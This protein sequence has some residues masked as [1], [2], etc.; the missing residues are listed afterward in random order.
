MKKNAKSLLKFFMALNFLAVLIT[1]YLTMMH[2]DNSLAEPCQLNSFLDCGVVNKSKYSLLFGIPVSVLGLLNYT[3]LVIS[4][5]VI[6]LEKIK[7]KKFLNFLIAIV[8]FGIGFSLYLTYIEFF[9][10]RAACILCLAQ[11]VII[12][13]DLVALLALKRYLKE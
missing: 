12:I 13:M 11:Q 3:F 9:V 4:A 1:I 7:S 6:Y 10:I 5:L 2:Y 8:V